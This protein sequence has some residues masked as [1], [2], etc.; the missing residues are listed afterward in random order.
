MGPWAS[1]S[2]R[3]LEWPGIDIRP[4][5]AFADTAVP[6]LGL[7][8]DRA[9]ILADDPV[10]VAVLPV[11]IPAGPHGAPVGADLREAELVDIADVDSAGLQEL[12]GL[13][14]VEASVAG[15]NSVHQGDPEGRRGGEGRLGFIDGLKSARGVVHGSYG[16]G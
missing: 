2:A 6:M 9:P 11:G 4:F 3:L 14:V 5:D 8:A 15:V 7:K 1:A 12:H 13:E 16:A 10:S